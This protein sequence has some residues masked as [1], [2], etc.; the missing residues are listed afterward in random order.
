MQLPCSRRAYALIFGT[1]IAATAILNPLLLSRPLLADETISFRRH[2]LPILSNHCFYCHG[3]DDEARQADLRLDDPESARHVIDVTATDSELFR[4]IT[5]DDADEQMPPPTANKPLS[6]SHID[7]IRQWIDQGAPW[8]DH[9]SWT[10][11]TRPTLPPVDPFDGNTLVE[12]PI[13]RFIQAK[14]QTLSRQPAPAAD[15]TT[16][17]RRVTLD[18]TGLPPSPTQRQDYARDTHPNAYAR[19]VDR[20]LSAPSFGER[21]AWNWLDAARYADSNGYQGDRDRTMW[22]WRDWVV[23]AFNESMPY[24]QFTTW[25][26]AGDLIDNPNPQSVL[27]TGFCRNH[28]INGEGGRIPEENRVD[29]IMDMTETMG[30][31]W[32][33]LTLN[34]CRCH[35]H[36]FDQLSREDYYRLFAF[37]NQTPI[38]GGGG[39]PQT[40][41]VLAVPTRQQQQQVNR[42]RETLRDLE[43][44]LDQRRQQLAKVRS[45]WEQQ[46]LAQK[47]PIVPAET[48]TA[49]KIPVK[50]RST[51]QQ[52]QIVQSQH[53][54]DDEHQKLTAQHKTVTDQRNQ[55]ES[56]IAK[57]MV[58]Q[59]QTEY[60]S[61]FMLERG[62]YN[63]QQREVTAGVP[64]S[65]PALADSAS[66]NRLDLANWIID[67]DN[68]LTTRVTVN[69]IWQQVFGIG[70]VKTVEDFGVQGEVP[71]HLDLLNW[72]ACEF[73]DTDWDIK[74][75]LRL[76]VTSHTYR[77]TSKIQPRDHEFDPAN[78]LLAHGARYRMP[79]WMLRDQAL[80]VSGLL[81][82]TVG[83]APVRPYQPKGVWSEATFGN[84]QYQP[85]SGADLYRRSLYTFW[86]RIAAPT[87]F[88]DTASRQT[89]TVNEV[90]TNTPLHAL[91]T[92]NDTT[93]VE[94]ARALA[95]IALRHS[96]ANDLKRIDFVIQRVLSRKVAD[97]EL[98]ILNQGLQRARGQFKADPTSAAKLLHVGESHYDES[99]DTV[100]TASWTSL[101][102]AILNLDET[103]TR[104]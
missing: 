16:L 29:Y 38:N 94:A 54:A 101:C 8:G 100:E 49:L 34:C 102:L 81:V 2:V 62:L 9:W 71:V 17:L 36:K 13:D 42:L 10:P 21:M 52:Q 60:R 23:A 41:P 77:Q 35:D 44:R 57:V 59:D 7:I 31:V 73:R 67:R 53:D 99:F 46:I 72:L 87:M 64:Q 63:K 47:I 27:A 82:R 78:R 103:L 80:A 37:F 22:P 84:R 88:F 70:L 32:L 75:L 24:D 18:L 98:Q 83:G 26:L 40:K 33:G 3:P 56:T 28:M 20:V 5:T 15:R 86:R 97:A 66:T 6:S 25:Q 96:C 19:Y 92:L 30:T 79:S 74:H 68:P 69:R 45:T 91:L 76:I 43:Q 90:R 14:L 4:R 48:L 12:N 11:L 39:D 55:L 93:Y 61:T 95:E 89:C 58:M 65:L 104:E 85:D 1:V 51:E 50:N